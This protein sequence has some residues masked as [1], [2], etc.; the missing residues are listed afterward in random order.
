MCKMLGYEYFST[1]TIQRKIAA[2]RGIDT[3]QLN[4]DCN[5]DKSVDDYIDGCLRKMNVDGTDNVILDSR[6]AWFFVSK[7]FKVYLTAVPSVA[8]E[9]VFNDKIRKGEPL[10]DVDKVMGNLLE[11][12]KVENERFKTFY[13]ADCADLDNFDLIVDTSYAT[14]DEIAALI[15]KVFKDASEGLAYDRR[16]TSVEGL[17]LV[18]YYAE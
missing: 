1:G 8:A 6:M 3:L 15:I 12:Q 13:G 10:G 14:V 17:S 4:K 7:S 2:E 18:P 11:R 16:W 9:R 5:N